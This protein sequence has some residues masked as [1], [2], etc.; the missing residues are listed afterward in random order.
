[1]T[2]ASCRCQLEDETHGAKIIEVYNNSKWKGS[3]IEVSV[4]KPGFME[5][6]AREWEDRE[7]EEAARQQSVLAR[8][9]SASLGHIDSSVFGT[10][11]RIRP[12]R[13]AQVRHLDSPG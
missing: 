9:Q 10:V 4:A 8:Q 12:K 6:L 13:N 2:H 11:L 1:M 7:S 5:R 3:K